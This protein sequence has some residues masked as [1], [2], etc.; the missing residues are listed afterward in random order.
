MKPTVKPSFFDNFRCIGSSCR[1]SCCTGFLFSIRRGEERLFPREAWTEDEDGLHL[2]T[3]PNGD[4]P[5]WTPQHLCARQHG[6]DQGSLPRMCRVFPRIAVDYPDRTEHLLD[7]LCPEVFRLVSTWE[8]GDLLVKGG[9][10]P[11]DFPDGQRK[12]QME[13]YRSLDLP[14]VATAFADYLRRLGAYMAFVN[15]PL[16]S[17]ELKA[18]GVFAPVRRFILEMAGRSHEF[19]ALGD[20]YFVFLCREWRRYCPAYGFDVEVE[21]YNGFP[22]KARDK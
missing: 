6:A 8:I 14:G 1:V 16:Y 4:C 11:E 7:V 3:R 22:G 19:A 21:G 10:L 18:Q 13:A 5:F 20:D 9:E 2:V 15:Y 12:E 17:R